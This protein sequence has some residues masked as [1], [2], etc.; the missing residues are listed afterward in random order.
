VVPSCG[1]NIDSPYDPA[2]IPSTLLAT[3]DAIIIRHIHMENVFNRAMLVIVEQV[4]NA[5]KGVNGSG[6]DGIMRVQIK[7]SS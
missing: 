4:A 7:L 6:R 5:R 3:N 2:N 1:R